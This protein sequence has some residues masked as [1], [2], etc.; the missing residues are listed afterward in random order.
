MRQVQDQLVRP[1]AISRLGRPG[2]STAMIASA[3]TSDGIASMT[4]VSP[5]TKS[6]Q[7]PPKYPA[8]IPSAA[9]MVELMSCDTTPTSS[10]TRAP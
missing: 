7:T 8:D 6:S 9:P 4:L 1:S 2:P 5:L 3:N 10:D